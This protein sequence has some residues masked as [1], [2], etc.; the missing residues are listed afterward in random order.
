LHD[1]HKILFA[2]YLFSHS[3]EVQVDKIISEEYVSCN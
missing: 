2:R 3:F 1:Y